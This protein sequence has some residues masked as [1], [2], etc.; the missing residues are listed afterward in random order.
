IQCLRYWNQDVV[1]YINTMMPFGGALAGKLISKKVIYHVHE[2]SLKPQILKKFLRSVISLTAHKVI[3]VS[4]Y[5]QEVENFK[6]KKQV[7]I[8]NALERSIVEEQKVVKDIF[9]VL[10]I[11]S[12]KE[13]KGVFEFIQLAQFLNDVK[14]L[15][16]Q[17]VLSATKD[18]IN[19]YLKGSEKPSNLVIFDR[20]NDLSK[21]Y[22]KASLLLNLSRPDGWIET[23]GLTILEGMEYGLPAVVPPVGGPTEIVREGIDGF[24][25]SCYETEKIAEKIQL[26]MENKDEYL[27]LSKNARERV[28]EFDIK[29]FEEKICEVV[30]NI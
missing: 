20:Q 18:E 22:E 21:F 11:C 6:N 8:Y 5:L 13:Y 30:E 7:V 2:T 3:F 1:F 10:M 25:I 26:L 23:F 29:V 19:E 27:R 24:Q 16:F 9:I 4:E 14:E 15:Q 28:K 12:L 17:L